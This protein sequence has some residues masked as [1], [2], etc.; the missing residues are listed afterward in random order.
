M[1]AGSAALILDDDRQ[2][3]LAARW[4]CGLRRTDGGRRRWKETRPYR[5][6]AAAG[7]REILSKQYW[8]IIEPA[9]YMGSSGKN[10]LGYFCRKQAP[11]YTNRT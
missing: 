11:A 4:A 6:K 9:V 5:L 8:V 1:D 10:V 7:Q 2:V 3:D